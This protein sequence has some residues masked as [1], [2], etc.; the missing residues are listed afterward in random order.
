MVLSPN[1]DNIPEDEF[2]DYLD[3]WY[4]DERFEGM[5]LRKIKIVKV[6]GLDGRRGEK[7]RKN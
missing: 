7:Q 6:G 5:N 4:G 1:C 3:E 2:N